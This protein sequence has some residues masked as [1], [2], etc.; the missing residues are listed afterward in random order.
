MKNQDYRVFVVEDD[1]F[2][3]QL[4]QT[5]LLAQGY[6]DTQIFYTGKECLDNLHEKPTIVFL[7]Y[8]LGL[9]NGH[10][11][12]KEIKEQCPDCYVV[13]LSG[14]EFLH[15]AVKSFKFGAFE[16]IEK[17]NKALENINKV[18]EKIKLGTP[19]KPIDSFSQGI[20]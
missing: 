11:I 4:V 14:Q 17:N 6:I 9:Y 12:L 3:A 10:E 7:D 16:Y 19:N 2:Y 18:L 8:A 1:K 20:I 5:F 13:M 15:I